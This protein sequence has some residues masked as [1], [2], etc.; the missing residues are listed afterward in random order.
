[1][2][3]STYRRRDFKSKPYHPKEYRPTEYKPTEI[4][5]GYVTEIQRL[6]EIPLLP[7]QPPS[8]F[9]DNP[10]HEAPRYPLPIQPVL[11]AAEPGNEGYDIHKPTC[12]INLICYRSRFGGCEMRQ[13]QVT[14]RD[15]FYTDQFYQS[16]IK[17]NPDLVQTDEAFFSRVR[18]IYLRDM[19]GFWRR[20][21]ALK[22]QSSIGLLSVSPLTSYPHLYLTRI[23]YTPTT[24]PQPISLPLPPSK[25]S[26]T[27]F[28]TPQKRVLAICGS[29]GYSN[30]DRKTIDM[31]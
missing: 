21:F 11:L 16:A 29:I 15:C 5:Q 14:K 10:D 17:D 25:K 1:M 3:S 6:D 26:S 2:F 18:R 30:F 23:K 22:T 24:H 9:S 13:T 12:A 4:T 19:C 20:N 31:P 7:V 27:H 8:S 28:T